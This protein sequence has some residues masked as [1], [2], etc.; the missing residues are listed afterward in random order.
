[1][2]LIRFTCQKSLGATCLSG[3]RRLFAMTVYCC[4]FIAVVPSWGGAE[5]VDGVHIDER[6]EY[7][8]A[9][10][11]SGSVWQVIQAD[12]AAQGPRFLLMRVDGADPGILGEYQRVKD[13]LRFMPRFALRPS[14]EY[15]VEFNPL[16]QLA[17]ANH[18]ATRRLT[19]K[20]PAPASKAPE[21]VRQVY[22]TADQLPENL[23]KFYIQFSGP[24]SQ[25]EAYRRIRLVDEDGKGI[26]LPFLELG[27]ELWD[28]AGTRL[29]LLFDPGRVK[30]G[31]KPRKDEGQ[32]L[33][34]GRQYRLVIDSAWSDATGQPLAADFEK[35]FRVT[36]ADYQQPDPAVWKLK[37]PTVETRTPLVITFREALDRGMLERIFRVEYENGQRV[38]TEAVVMP[39][40]RAVELKPRSPWKAGRFRLRFD[41]TLEDVAG[42]SV[43]RAFE[44]REEDQPD[45]QSPIVERTFE[46]RR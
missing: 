12:L 37:R 44:V 15:V 24:M 20:L 32:V 34:A 6:G 8:D 13:R 25:G 4:G 26:E 28:P 40:E 19:F 11:L 5:N 14:L 1:M 35:R 17:T 39:G 18:R 7:V 41:P 3:C 31:L 33:H 36:A 9:G 46:L 29:T 2:H 42:N 21:R 22:P 30:R 27:Q 23:L 38:A 43:G 10:P 45:R 16:G